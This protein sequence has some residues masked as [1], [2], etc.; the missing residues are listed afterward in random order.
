[1]VASLIKLSRKNK[2]IFILWFDF[3]AIIGCLFA[4]FSIRLGYFYYPIGFYGDEKLLIVI[5][6]APL[7]ALPIFFHFEL[8]R[9][10]IRFVSFRS[11]WRIIQAVSL[12][13]IL[14][15]LIAFMTAN[16]E[17]FPRSVIIINWILVIIVIGGSRLIARWFLT[18]S[19]II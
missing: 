9:T 8:Y 14:W 17:A 10:V 15:G 3:I 12:Y 7:V 13:A 11:I 2:Q 6:T 4:A 18:Y 16:W 19:N 1:M 5:F